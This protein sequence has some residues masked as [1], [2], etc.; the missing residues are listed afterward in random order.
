L[1]LHLSRTGAARAK[2][3]MIRILV[4]E[5]Q[6]L[7]R[8][9]LC[10][11]FAVQQDMEVAGQCGTAEAALRMLEETGVDVLVAS[12]RL[13]PGVVAA[14]RQQGAQGILVITDS[15]EPETSLAAFHAGARAILS[16]H[17]SS[18]TLTRAIRV[19]ASGGAWLDQ[20]TIEVLT[21]GARVSANTEELSDR[22]R[23][24][25][26]GIA[27][28]MTNRR[29]AETMGVSEAAIKAALHR[30]YVK[31]Q[32]GTRAQLVRR[33]LEGAFGGQKAGPRA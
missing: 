26:R 16:R 8:E 22:E 5:D 10:H 13:G 20:A 3:T 15:V 6:A 12:G 21:A 24:I 29:I 14:A 32:T 7:F 19:V 33:V 23:E 25:L 17:S 4:V 9:S 18:E 2:S 30:L 27:D 11:L 28:G 1:V 31:T